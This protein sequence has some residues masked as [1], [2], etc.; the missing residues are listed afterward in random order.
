MTL[1]V[2]IIILGILFILFA[3]SI[4]KKAMMRISLGILGVILIINPSADGFNV[5]AVYA[6]IA[7]LLITVRDLITRKLSS[8]VH[9]LLP[10]VSASMGVLLFSIILMVNTSL[11]PLNPQNSLFIFLAA[12]F[13]IFG[14][15]TAVLVMRNGEISFISPFRYSAILFA[16][17]IGFILFDETPD[18]VALVGIAIV[19]LAGIILMIRNN[20]VKKFN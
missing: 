2:L 4:R 18:K 16:L 1:E 5:Y 7:V 10:T 14:Y 20:S 13:I 3:V 6:L 19:M 17:I 12:F 11:K 15:Y 9:T 8:E